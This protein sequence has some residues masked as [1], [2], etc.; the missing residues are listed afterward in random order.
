[1]IAAASACWLLFLVNC[2]GNEPNHNALISALRAELPIGS[3]SAHI[4]TA[5]NKHHLIWTF[6]KYTNRYICT[7]RYPGGYEGTVIDLYVRSGKLYRFEAQEYT[8]WP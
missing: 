7:L 6:D 1:M 4:V 5:L 3:S 2:S 8:T